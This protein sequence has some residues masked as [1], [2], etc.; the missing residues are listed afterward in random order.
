MLFFFQFSFFS[1]NWPLSSR[2]S[3]SISNFSKALIFHQNGEKRIIYQFQST[4][5]RCEP[6]VSK[7]VDVQKNT[8]KFTT[9]KF[10]LLL[11]IYSFAATP[12]T[13]FDAGIWNLQG[14]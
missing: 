1:E 6:Q 5:Y 11:S 13:V 12:L 4:K 2:T 7:I 8:D 9:V 3:F 10:L 14:D